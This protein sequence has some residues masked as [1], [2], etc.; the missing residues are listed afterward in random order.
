MIPLLF[1]WSN[2]HHLPNWLKRADRLV[3]EISFPLYIIHF[4]ILEML[5]FK[6]HWQ[7]SSKSLVG[8]VLVLSMAGSIFILRY[9]M[10]PLEAIRGSRAKNNRNRIIDNAAEVVNP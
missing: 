8:S 4:P 1:A 9:I 5:L 2:S 3:G 6:G 7:W 10:E